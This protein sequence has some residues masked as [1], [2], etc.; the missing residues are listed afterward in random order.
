[1]NQPID[2]DEM[3]K[4]LGRC[5]KKQYE[6]CGPHP[7]YADVGQK[8]PPF[9]CMNWKEDAAQNSV[10]DVSSP[11]LPAPQQRLN[12]ERFTIRYCGNYG[13]TVSIPSYE[14]GEVVR[15]E[16]FDAM[17]E[18]VAKHAAQLEWALG[19]N[20]NSSLSPHGVAYV[21]EA[22]RELAAALAAVADKEK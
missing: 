16:A 17:R 22:Q 7:R 9:P 5:D 21:R 11:A 8:L 12:T 2:G 3:K 19:F 20:E 4:I 1:M 15:A 10:A 18:V 13:Y 6:H 14:G